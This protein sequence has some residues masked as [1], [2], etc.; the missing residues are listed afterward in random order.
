MTVLIIESTV[1]ASTT[2]MVI[3]IRAVEA[4]NVQYNS[5]GAN[6]REWKEL[7]SMDVLA[8]SVKLSPVLDCIGA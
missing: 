1:A 3:F 7:S 6:D 4:L 5:T 2:R 8:N